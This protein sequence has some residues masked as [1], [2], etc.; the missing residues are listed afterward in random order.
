MAMAAAPVA[1]ASDTAKSVLEQGMRVRH[2]L[3]GL[4]GRAPRHGPLEHPA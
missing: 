1:R 3:T 2:R 4:V